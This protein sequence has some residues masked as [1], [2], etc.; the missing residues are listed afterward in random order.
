MNKD[1]RAALLAALLTLAGLTAKSGDSTLTFAFM[2]DIMMGTTFPDDSKG[3]Y[4]PENDGKDLFRH[5]SA[6]IQSADIAAANL[7]GTLLDTP[8]K[9]KR[10]GDPKLCYAFRTPTSYVNNLV[11]AGL[12]FMSV[13]NNHINDMGPEGVTSTLLALKGAGIAAAGQ[14]GAADTAI[15]ERDSLLIGFSAFSPCSGSL[16]ILDLE[17][18]RRITAELKDRSDI[19]V[20]SFHGGAE[21]P[22]ATRVPHSMETAFGERR[23]NVEEF[24]H[25]AID[26]GADIVYGHGPHVTRAMEIY[27][28]RLIIYSLG[29]FCTPYRMN[30]NGV[31]G[32]APVVTVVTDREGKFLRGRIH[33]FVQQK[34]K[35]PQPDTAGVV[36]RNIRTLSELDFPATK[37][38]INPDGTFSSGRN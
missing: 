4:L 34:G 23:G 25:A 24:A 15:L 32:H 7:E 9:P 6:V 5:V 36:I 29:N 38:L 10:C 35:G 31:T 8:G 1:Y 16:S 17:E 33:P 30:L 28:D 2:G 3:I 21:G 13:A 12:D 14:R 26:A 19:V 20:I 22:K 18:M 11:D 37:P 27:K